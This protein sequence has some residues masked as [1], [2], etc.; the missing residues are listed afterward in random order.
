LKEVFIHMQQ[1]HN[2]QDL[3]TRGRREETRNQ[4]ERPWRERKELVEKKQIE[5]I[6]LEWLIGEPRGYGSQGHEPTFRRQEEER[7]PWQVLKK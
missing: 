5:E 4:E 2:G 6:H 1:E 3:E 7:E